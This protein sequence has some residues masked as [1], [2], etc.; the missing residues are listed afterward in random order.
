VQTCVTHALSGN[1][2]E[3]QQSKIEELISIFDR[4]CNA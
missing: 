2:P 4:Y 1:D 3:D